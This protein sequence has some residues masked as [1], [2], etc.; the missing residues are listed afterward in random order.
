MDTQDTILKNKKGS[1]PTSLS[2]PDNHPIQPNLN[3]SRGSSIQS[4]IADTQ[5][6]K[7][8]INK[9][10]LPQGGGALQGIGET[11]IPNAFTGNGSYAIPF[12][13]TPIRGFEPQ[14][15]LN[16]NSGAGNSPFGLGF[17]LSNLKISRRTEKGIPK[18]DESDIFLDDQGGELTPKLSHNAPMKRI[19]KK[20]TEHW[21][22]HEYLPRVESTF[23]K[24]EYWLN[25]QNQDSYWQVITRDNT[26]MTFGQ[27]PQGRISD[28][29]DPARVFEWLLEQS[30]DAKDNKICFAYKAENNDQVP[31]CSW[32]Q[33]RANTQKYLQRIQYGNF[34]DE[35]QQEQFAIEVILD[36]GEYDL[37]TLEQG[38]KNPHV[39]TQSWNYRQ[40]AFSS[41]RS[42]FEVRTRRRCQ[43][44]L[45]FHHF[46]Q[47]LGDPCLVKRLALHYEEPSTLTNPAKLSFLKS[48]T[49][50]G[51]QRVGQAATDS[52]TLQALPPLEFN[53]SK[54]NPPQNP[55]FKNL[56]IAPSQ[57]I[58]GFLNGA[59]FQGVDL[60]AEG[61]SGLLYNGSNSLFYLRPE[62]DGFLGRPEVLDLFPTERD[63]DN[64]KVSLIDL[65]GNGELEL[66]VRDSGKTGF[67]PRQ[68][69]GTW[70]RYQDF[71]SY[72]VQFDDALLE[73]VS[74][75]AD[76]K[77]DLLLDD[78][79]DLVVYPSQGKQGYAAGV[80]IPK[81]HHFPRQQ[82]DYPEEQIHFTNLLGDGLS[83][84]VRIANGVV[85]CWP[86]L[87]HGQFGERITLGNAPTFEA[88]F[89]VS[90]LFLAD[91]D[92]S[93]T[94]DLIY[95][96]PDK[97]KL[98]LN[99]NGNSFA[100]PITIALPETFGTLDQLTFSDVL[101]NGTT[102]LVLSK[103][104]PTPRH[105]YYS[106]VGETVVD[107][108]TMESLKPYLLIEIDNHLGAVTE[109]QY[110]SSVKFYLADKNQGRPW[111]TKLPFPVQVVE[112]VITKD[113]IS[114][115]RFVQ[116]FA[117]H[118]GFYDTV[119][120]EFRGFGYVESWDTENYQDYRKHLSGETP[121]LAENPELYVPPV[122]TRTW[123]HTGCYIH[124][125]Q[126]SGHYKNQYYQ[127]DTQA[128]SLP[129]S[130]LPPDCSDAET[131][132]QAQIA[133]KGQVLRQEVYAKDDS[134]YAPHPYSVTESNFEVRLLQPRNHQEFAAFLTIPRESVSSHYERNP[135]DPKVEQQFHLEVDVF[136]NIT[137]SC[138][139]F[140]PR[141]SQTKETVYPEQQTLK[142][143]S[144]LRHFIN[145][146]EAFHRIGVSYESQVL[147]LGG[148]S[149]PQ[150]I[151]YFT[152]DE[153]QIQAEK[154]LENRIHHAAEFT[155]E[156]T[157]ARQLSWNRS[158]FWNE[159]QTQALEL[160]KLTAKALVHH[161]SVADFP[162]EFINNAFAGRLTEATIADKGGFVLDPETQ[163]WWNQGLVQ[164]YYKAEQSEHFFMTSH[165]ENSFVEPGSE[166]YSKTVIE[167][168][169]YYAFPTRVSE[170]LDEQTEN[171]TQFKTDYRTC[172]TQQVI[173]LNNNVTQVLFDP[174]GQVVVSTLFGTQQ[175]ARVGGMRLYDEEGL[176][177][178]YIPRA[179][180]STGA[181]IDFADVIAHPDHYLQGAMSYFYYDLHAWQN[182]QQPIS[183]IHLVGQDYHHRPDQEPTTPCQVLVSYNDGLGR[184]LASKLKTDQGK[185][186]TTGHTVYNNKGNACQQYLPYFS[187][188]PAYE[189][190][191]TLPAPPPTILQYDP[192]ERVIKTITPK[193]LF[194]KVKFDPWQEQH[195]DENDT[196]IDSVYYQEFMKLPVADLD[197]TQKDER[198]AL[199]KAA[200]CHDTPTQRIMDSSGQAFLEIE[201]LKSKDDPEG[202]PLL[203][204]YQTDLL[205]RVT[206]SIDARLY[207]SNQTQQTAYYNFKYQ[208]TMT[209]EAPAYTD[210]VDGGITR[211][212]SNIYGQQLWSLSPR[213]YCQLIGY[214]RLQRQTTLRVKQIEDE[215][216]I[217]DFD[218]FSLVETTHYGENHANAQ[219]LNLR[220]QPHEMKDLSGVA[221]NTLYDLQG[222]VLQTSRQM[223][224]DYKTPVDWNQKV[225]LEETV[226]INT[227]HYNALGKL[228]RQTTPDGSV[229]SN[230]YNQIGLLNGV[231][232]TFKH[233]TDQSIVTQI[234]YDPQG[235]RTQIIYGNRVVTNYQYE[236]TTLRLIG[237]SSSRPQGETTGLVQD[238]RYTYDGVGNITRLRDNSAQ[239]VF[240]KNQKVEPLSD[241]HYDS[242]YRL[243]QANGRQ[244][245]G[246]N[247]TAFQ[248]H[249]QDNEFLQIQ[250]KQL[251]EMNEAD[252]L[253]NYTETY[254]YDDSGNLILKQ[255]QAAS[256]SWN[257][258]TPVSENSNR[259]KD[260]EYDD[261]GNLR[262]LEVGST[263]E[264]SFNCCDNLVRAQ[265]I[266]RPDGNDDCDHYL[267][268]SD[269][270][271]T[272]KVSE[273]SASGGK[274]IH[275]EEKIYLGNYEIKRN[276]SIGPE[277]DQKMAL[278]RQ[279]L[280]IMDD[281]S[282]VAICHYW[283][284]DDKQQ[285]VDKAGERSV[286]FQLGTH[287]ESV[288]VELNQEA[289]LISYEEYFPYGGTAL[290]AGR[291]QK[292]VKTKDY[293][294]SG[295]ERDN[296]TGLYYYGMRYYAPWLGR[297]LNP[298]PAGTVDGM[299]VY[300]FVGGNPI[301][302]VDGKGLMIVQDISQKE[303]FSSVEPPPPSYVSKLDPIGQATLKAHE[304]RLKA[305][306]RE[307]IKSAIID[308]VNAVRD[309]HESVKNTNDFQE[310]MEK[311]KEAYHEYTMGREALKS[312][313]QFGLLFS[314]KGEV[315]I[316]EVDTQAE[317]QDLSWS[318]LKTLGQ[319][320][321]NNENS[322][323]KLV[324]ALKGVGML[325]NL[326]TAKKEDF[327]GL[328][329]EIQGLA[330]D[331]MIK[332]GVSTV[333]GAVAGK[334]MLKVGNS[335]QQSP[336]LRVKTA[337]TVLAIGGYGAMGA[338]A[339]ASVNTMRNIGKQYNALQNDPHKKE[340]LDLMIKKTQTKMRDVDPSP[341][342]W[343]T[344]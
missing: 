21:E 16:Y 294:Y 324:R 223:I 25:P 202:R 181:P 229:T 232:V 102:C 122:Y 52:Y 253:E 257:Q 300:A 141:R 289:K 41:Y 47:E 274:I 344:S 233:E 292:E 38:G 288:A 91:L 153:I 222:N 298:D 114:G 43:N 63:F 126:A 260:L 151:D 128:H 88:D 240:H 304:M 60:D 89:N 56:Q 319:A 312:A 33:N 203:H 251:P 75:R 24:W 266:G 45:L 192:L 309:F 139:V 238:I 270:Q 213:N 183:A 205:G 206:Q 185:W 149:L 315:K 110:C 26:T 100:D 154:A 48:A 184:E 269:E 145:E 18:Y 150:G 11:F 112:K 37:E 133:L 36:Y 163:Y 158:Y 318:E 339:L 320:V 218:D 282:C 101:G 68:S 30:I 81:P 157:Q 326:V 50:I 140:L 308:R 258:E 195:F 281:Q 155:E 5:V 152:F 321:A 175:E 311:I 147:E 196:L 44:I 107:G 325:T 83:H 86:N 279:T 118:D 230:R 209:G 328:D 51:Y 120:R 159:K 144:S 261:S 20:G 235:Q 310:D 97:V 210:S 127:G 285:E 64:G 332:L 314:T 166:L 198:D 123:H 53:F 169:P 293:H 80:R 262:K 186:Q 306:V 301:T 132:R 82:P 188:I 94:S 174:L 204:Y 62:G 99:Q 284:K 17:T 250:L 177:K 1:T 10:E 286:R 78:Q 225:L 93:G 136:G 73:T 66:V 248:H 316:P 179:T 31:P 255:H 12:P 160:G 69:D 272:R 92:G 329:S 14:L 119:E 208:Y 220:G 70:G 305:P 200:L 337:G 226:Y 267:Y 194:S 105:Y 191:T 4:L 297:W 55:Q 303:E 85:E 156:T 259:L 214:D 167:Y 42:G 327:K 190:Q 28:S 130:L 180:G 32:E 61:I 19:E 234:D 243:I 263:M 268:D 343:F 29:N 295:K 106:F 224:L 331:H 215:T 342:N 254:H 334:G 59:G 323:Y 290:V 239:M 296:S 273:R 74:T 193:K 121:L 98:F 241:Y 131:W 182:R 39:P 79:D 338:G 108:Q 40:D 77:I 168:D 71:E 142:V 271:R 8:E 54:F 138:Q 109:M 247:K 256:S 307:G 276:K 137:H 322:D 164:H 227:F 199:E 178:E 65:E 207:Q 57:E 129:D 115:A 246:I 3:E 335:L 278:E 35:N 49:L 242:L 173:D 299:N 146:T 219:K 333:A 76:G 27:T 46:T 197:Q 104:A 162:H 13:L 313:L 264:L 265:V 134:E 176:P 7:I 143:A 275:V 9:P 187:E 34:I 95:M 161:Q 171:I 58:P 231:Q 228:V 244:H 87:G 15:T 172:Q 113:Q 189:P 249:A 330:Q 237:L 117:Y 217:T 84:R 96:Y 336:S 341:P 148:L 170:Y 283:T 2:T 23:S 201:T 72:P 221:R 116:Q 291:N 317:Y 245:P 280:R 252:K 216:P 22:V 67:Y 6:P 287:Q 236:T 135:Q 340:A 212:L 90:R 277:G 111:L 211:H 103:I 165:V 124:V 302:L 125:S